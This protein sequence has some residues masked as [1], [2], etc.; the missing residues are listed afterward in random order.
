MESLQDTDETDYAP[1]PEFD[2]YESNGIDPA[3]SYNNNHSR[4]YKFGI[5]VDAEYCP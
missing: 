3:Q 4:M 1:Q 5:V 2:H